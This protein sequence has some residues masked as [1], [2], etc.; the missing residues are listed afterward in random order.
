MYY[1]HIN[2]VVSCDTSPELGSILLK[3]GLYAG[4]H[5]YMYMNHYLITR[6]L[7]LHIKPGSHCVTESADLAN[8]PIIPWHCL[9]LGLGKWCRKWHPS[10]AI[11]ITLRSV[12]IEMYIVSV[13]SVLELQVPYWVC[14]HQWRSIDLS[15][16]TMEASYWAYPRI[17]WSLSGLMKFFITSDALEHYWP[18]LRYRITGKDWLV[19]IVELI[20]PST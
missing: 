4:M 19:Y 10:L 1:F 2:P 18:C 20:K 13:T 9:A 14:M 17:P 15:G 8:G 7:W 3:M 6:E 12:E 5:Q 16:H 11:I